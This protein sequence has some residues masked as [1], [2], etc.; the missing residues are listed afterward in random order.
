[1]S[2]KEIA[3]FIVVIICLVIVFAGGFALGKRTGY[4]E[5][6]ANGFSLNKESPIRQMYL[7]SIAEYNEARDRYNA[8]LDTLIEKYEKELDKDG[9]NKNDS[10]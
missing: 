9:G 1:M 2:E 5:G 10:E 3:T 7:E 4:N 6:Y 8:K